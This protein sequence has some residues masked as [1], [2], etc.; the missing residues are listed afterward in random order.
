MGGLRDEMEH[1]LDEKLQAARAASFTELTLVETTH[2]QLAQANQSLDE[3]RANLTR[4]LAD[5]C[6]FTHIFLSIFFFS[7]FL[8]FT[9]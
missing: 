3:A 1:D 9:T 4:A 2:T 8:F 6:S 5:V 7:L